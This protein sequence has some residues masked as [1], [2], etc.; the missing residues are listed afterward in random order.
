MVLI[1][2]VCK[3]SYKKFIDP[4]YSAGYS[5]LTF[6]IALWALHWSFKDTVCPLPDWYKGFETYFRNEKK[7]SG[8]NGFH[9]IVWVVLIGADSDTYGIIF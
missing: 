2:K 1:T 8:R 5:V 6:R 4:S 3:F 9:C 7:A